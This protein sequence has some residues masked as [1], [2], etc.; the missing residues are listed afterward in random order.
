MTVSFTTGV[1]WIISP[2]SFPHIY[3][4]DWEKNVGAEA[5]LDIELIE[6]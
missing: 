3:H 4:F 5:G 2:R 6:G 1:G